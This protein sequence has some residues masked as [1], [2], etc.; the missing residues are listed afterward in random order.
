MMMFLTVTAYYKDIFDYVTTRTAK[1]SSARFATQSF[2]TYVNS[3]YARSRGLEV[4]YK[5]RIDK[6]FTGDASVFLRYCNW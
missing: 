4:E 2:I 6:W 3:D 1:I 5:K